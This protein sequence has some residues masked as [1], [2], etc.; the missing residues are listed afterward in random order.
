[1]VSVGLDESVIK[2]KCTVRPESA[3]T[4]VTPF[5]VRPPAAPSGRRHAQDGG[6]DATEEELQRVRGGPVGERVCKRKLRVAL[7]WLYLL[8]Y[9][10]PH[11]FVVRLKPEWST[12]IG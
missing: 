6:V 7:N 12:P 5:V 10:G 3:S 1:M 2:S 4:T 8:F 11:M 9:C